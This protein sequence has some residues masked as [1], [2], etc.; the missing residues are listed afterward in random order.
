MNKEAALED[1]SIC[2]TG[3]KLF[4][5]KK[6]FRLTPQFS[7]S[8]VLGSSTLCPVPPGCPSICSVRL[9]DLCVLVRS[10]HSIVGLL[11][12]KGAILDATEE[13]QDVICSPDLPSLLHLPCSGQRRC[14]PSEGQCRLQVQLLADRGHGRV[15]TSHRVNSSFTLTE[16][17]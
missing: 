1:I 17:T 3:G 10:S 4:P 16:E 2:S 13:K 12:S 7:P 6:D 15:K 5:P 9:P 14:K 11:P 8:P